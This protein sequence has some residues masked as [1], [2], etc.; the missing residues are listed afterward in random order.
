[1]STKGGGYL[2][3]DFKKWIGLSSEL[4]LMQEEVKGLQE[5]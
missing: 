5:S 1:M 4:L 3:K 2:R